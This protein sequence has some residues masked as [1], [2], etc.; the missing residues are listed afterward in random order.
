MKV[1]VKGK[2][3]YLDP[4]WQTFSS[5]QVYK[6][7]GEGKESAA[8]VSSSRQN[9]KA[10]HNFQLQPRGSDFLSNLLEVP[11]LLITFSPFHTSAK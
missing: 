6:I 9:H 3:P 4:V 1:R 5:C 2:N 7:K 10:Q 8:S 11:A